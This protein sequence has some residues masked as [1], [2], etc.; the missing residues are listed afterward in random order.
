MC[1]YYPIQI[2]LPTLIFTAPRLVSSWFPDVEH[3]GVV[4]TQ[5]DSF[6]KRMAL[7]GFKPLFYIQLR[8][9]QQKYHKP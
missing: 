1:V 6:I 4:S 7:T 8:T 3:Q 5:D 2:E 9:S